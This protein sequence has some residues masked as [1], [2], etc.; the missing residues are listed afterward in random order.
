M[1]SRGIEQMVSIRG[2][3]QIPVA[4]LGVCGNANVVDVVVTG[5][6]AKLQTL[7]SPSSDPE[8]IMSSDS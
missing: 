1:A 6:G 3:D 8:M 4:L 2:I 7:T 5:D